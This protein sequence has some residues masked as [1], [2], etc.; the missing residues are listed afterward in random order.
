MKN[1]ELPL[2]EAMKNFE[3]GVRLARSLEKEL[4]RIERRVEILVNNPQAED[5]KPEL[6]LFPGL[7]GE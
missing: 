2:E 1:G 7:D 3:E 5:E 6:E 4:E